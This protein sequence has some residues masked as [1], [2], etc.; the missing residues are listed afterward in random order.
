MEDWKLV[1][2]QKLSV[3]SARCITVLFKEVSPD[4]K[5]EALETLDPVAESHVKFEIRSVSLAHTIPDFIT[6]I[7]VIEELVPKKV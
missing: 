7:A 1:F 3:G 6:L 2:C 4:A 5:L